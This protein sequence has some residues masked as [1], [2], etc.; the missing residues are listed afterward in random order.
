LK[1]R[2][3]SKTTKLPQQFLDLPFLIMK[4]TTL[5]LD[6]S[7]VRLEYLAEG[8]AN[9]VYRIFP[10]TTD[11]STAADLSSEPNGYDSDTPLPTEITPLQ[12][13]PR[14]QGKLVRL[15]KDLPSAIPVADSQRHFESQIRPLFQ[16]ENLVEAT[17]FHPSQSLLKT[18]NTHLR[19]MEKNGIRPPKRHGAYLISDE[20]HGCLITD[21]SSSPNDTT[22]KSIEFKPK[23]LIQSPSA[24][25]GA[26]RCRTC[27][28]RAM[29][30][31]NTE[32]ENSKTAF[33]PLNLV[34]ID[35]T[36]V[37][38]FVDYIL[39]LS[40]YRNRLVDDESIVRE[41]EILLEYLYK[42]PLLDKLRTLQLELDT[43]GVFRADLMGERFLAAMTLR[44]CTLFLKVC[45]CLLFVKVVQ[46]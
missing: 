44:D 19:R 26:R 31:A 1:F 29:K 27:A 5:S 15:R 12:L 39:G 10:P 43:E 38:I 3:Y 11:P 16:P 21:M 9:I 35:R 36:K 22:L 23:W 6:L 4:N 20:P 8:A 25:A 37:S 7:D 13:D 34:S 18:C 40:P 24:P 41:H 28:L 30:H 33:C 45:R 46:F 14:L 32:K 2:L 42:N 17:L